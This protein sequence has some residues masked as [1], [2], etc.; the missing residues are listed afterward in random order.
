MTKIPKVLKQMRKPKNYV[1]APENRDSREKENGNIS[2][3][4]SPKKQG[5]QLMAWFFTYNNYP[6]SA[7][8][9]LETTFQQI[10]KKYIFQCEVGEEGTPHLQGQIFLKKKMRWSEFDLPL[11]MSWYKTKNAKAAVVYVGKEATSTGR[12]F[13]WGNWPKEAEPVR[14]VVPTYKWQTDLLFKLQEQPDDRTIN[15]YWE[16]EGHVGKSVLRR[17]N[18]IVNNATQVQKGKFSDIMNLVFETNM[19]ECRCIMFDL[20]KENGNHISYSAIE[21]LKD[22]C[23]TNTKYETGVAYF[24]P[25]HIVIFANEPPDTSKMT[26]DRWNIVHIDP[27]TEE[28]KTMEKKIV[29]VPYKVVGKAAKKQGGD[30]LF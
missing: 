10:C 9:R 11:Q 13:K 12:R 27:L 6:E 8:E 17:Y 4:S 15:W 28:E 23:I 24:N 29:L 25:P 30:T 14:V 3:P 26:G 19:D 7:I 20:P 16:T 5:N 22:G 21:A 2:S 1:S 18:I